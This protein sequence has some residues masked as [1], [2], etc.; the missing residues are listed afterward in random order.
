MIATIEIPKNSIYKYEK[1]LSDILVIDRV[2]NQR[3]VQNYGYINGLLKQADGDDLD[4]FVLSRD[5][6]I[7]LTIVKIEIKGIFYCTDKGIRDDKVVAVIAGDT[8]LQ[9]DWSFL[10]RELEDYLTTYKENFF[11]TGFDELTE[12]PADYFNLEHY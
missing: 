11:V 4:V 1:N 7:P 3:C 10:L 5:P 8:Y 2:L 12:I 9:D 6:I